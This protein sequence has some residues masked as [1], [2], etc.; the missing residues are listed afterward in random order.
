MRLVL[1]CPFYVILATRSRLRPH[2]LR[3]YLLSHLV[4]TS[5]GAGAQS[6]TVN[7][8]GCGFNP[9]SI[10]LNIY[11]KLLNKIKYLFKMS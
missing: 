9:H 5:R 4:E 10:K 11:L 2:V 6:M 3:N 7:A 1:S 8:T